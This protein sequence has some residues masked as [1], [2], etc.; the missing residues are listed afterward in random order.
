MASRAKSNRSTG[1]GRKPAPASK[2]DPIYAAIARHMRAHA[3]VIE[4][5]GPRDVPGRLV[6]AWTKAERELFETVPTT[7]MGLRA[8]TLH[9]AH[10][11]RAQKECGGVVNALPLIETLSRF[12]MRQVGS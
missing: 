9:S 12:S 11:I 10:Y 6:A 8:L 2:P 1:T 7:L 5:C 3:A 4:A